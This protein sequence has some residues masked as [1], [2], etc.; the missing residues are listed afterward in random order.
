VR[1]LEETRPGLLKK[2]LVEKYHPGEWRESLAAAYALGEGPAWTG[3][4]RLAA[5]HF[6]NISA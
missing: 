2:L 5:A 6:K 1:F 4:D 3:L